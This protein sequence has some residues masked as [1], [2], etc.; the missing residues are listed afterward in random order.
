VT[1]HGVV[2]A[3]ALASSL[4]GLPAPLVTLRLFMA[5]SSALE[6]LPPGRAVELVA[7]SICESWCKGSEDPERCMEECTAS[8]KVELERLLMEA[9]GRG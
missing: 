4:S 2:L 5:L 7:W 8:K 6:E 9:G 3:N 1:G